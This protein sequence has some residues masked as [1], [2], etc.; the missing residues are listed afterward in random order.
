MIEMWNYEWKITKCISY[1]TKWFLHDI[2]RGTCRFYW[3]FYFT[4]SSLCFIV[5]RAW[6]L[7]WLEPLCTAGLTR[8]TLKVYIWIHMMKLTCWPWTAYWN[9]TFVS[10]KQVYSIYMI[11]HFLDLKSHE[12]H[13]R[14]SN[15]YFY[16]MVLLLFLPLHFHKTLILL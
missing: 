5:I 14:K 3:P 13:I 9:I 16:H 12:I 15:I 1:K 6:I 2:I 11:H 10:L 4:Y 8:H 7:Y